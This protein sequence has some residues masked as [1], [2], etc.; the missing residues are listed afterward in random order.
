MGKQWNSD[1][2][3]FLELKKFTADDDCSHEIKRNLLLERKADKPKQHIKKQKHYFTLPTNVRL[4][5]AMVFPVIMCGWESWTIKKTECRR[6]DAFELCC[7]RR[8]LRV[9]WTA[10]RSNQLILKEIN[11]KYHWKEWCWS[12]SSNT[13]ASWCEELTHW[14]RPWCWERLKARGE[15]LTED[16]MA[17]WHHWLNGHKFEQATRDGDGQGSLA[18]CS[19][20]GHKESG[21][22]EWLNNNYSLATINRYGYVIQS[23]SMRYI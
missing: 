13:L 18:C 5:K 19:P 1:R 6:I 16:K 20:W 3:Y 23:W 9:P 14:K 2:L 21:M 22:T 15:G 12:F 11:P 17:G 8:L 4:V 10:R 7:W